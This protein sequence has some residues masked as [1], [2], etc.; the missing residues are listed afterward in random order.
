MDYLDIETTSLFADT[1]MLV[2]AV[3]RRNG[4]NRE[5]FVECPEAEKRTLGDL[6]TMLSECDE[7]VTFNGKSFDLPF[8]LSRAL[9]LG[10]E[11]PG[12]PPQFHLDLYEEFKRRFRFVKLSLG[13]LSHILGYD[14]EVATTGVDVPN[15]YLRYLADRDAELK[16]EI[17]RHCNSDVDLLQQIHH[18]LKPLFEREEDDQ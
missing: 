11:G 3:V 2:C 4:E 1:G 16:Q 12:L 9:V 5:F 18:R 13:H 6:L 10:I 15:L 14:S 7:L 8:I 17:L